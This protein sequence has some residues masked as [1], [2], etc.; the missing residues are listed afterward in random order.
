MQHQFPYTLLNKNELI[1]QMNRLAALG[2]A[3]VFIVDYKANSGYII[4]KEMLDANYIRFDFS[5][6]KATSQNQ[7]IDWKIEPISFERYKEKVAFVKN[8]ICRGNS[9]LC[10][11]TQ[12]TKVLS[13]ASL[14]DIYNM[15]S[16]KYKLWFRNE[17][18]AEF[19]TLSPETFVKIEGRKIASFPMKGTIDANLPNAAEHILCDKKESAEHATIVDLIRNDL[20]IVA[21]NVTVKRYR[22][23]DKIATN[24]G[25]LL[26]V[27]SEICGELAKD[28]HSK[29]G[30]IIFAL[31]P[32]GSISGAPK[33]KTMWIIE[34]A[35]TYER[36]FYTGIC[37]YFDGTNLDSAVMI[38]FIEQNNGELT[39]KSGG[40]ITAQ[41]NVELEY[42]EL[43][44]KVYVPMS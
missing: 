17:Q 43:I 8:Q 21:E 3:F 7:K 1:M 34:N 27:S 6:A 29:L 5:N 9:F 37:G 41:S 35:E 33:Q 32:A 28:F 36:G 4:E 18:H 25:A 11:L 12:P 19:L 20:S 13:N 42:N 22:Y 26:Q 10:N 38:R 44:Q 15:S 14:S 16:A 40:G 39:F 30:D 23:I 24:K 2:K 31:L